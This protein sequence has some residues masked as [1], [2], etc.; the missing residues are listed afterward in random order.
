MTFFADSEKS[1]SWTMRSRNCL[2]VGPGTCTECS[3][4]RHALK[5]TQRPG[6]TE[7]KMN[8]P[9]SKVK[10]KNLIA[11]EVIELRKKEKILSSKLEEI[12]L[13]VDAESVFVDED[14][15]GELLHLFENIPGDKLDPFVRLFWNEQQKAFSRSNRGMRWHP[16]L[17]K[18]G[19]FIRQISP[20]LY[21]TLRN[22][23]IVKLPGQSTLRDYTGVIKTGA[24]FQH[25]VLLDLKEKASKLPESQKFV[26]I[27]HDEVTIQQ[28]LVFDK[29][30]STLVGYVAPEQLDLSK[31]KMQVSDEFFLT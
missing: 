21:D 13:R 4:V 6:V 17:I 7:L 30:S 26:C 31:V 25:H 16:M 28:D 5:K 12:Q 11:K 9:I 29:Q 23:G 1:S 24:G 15:N 19:I 22:M 8:A 18:F 20:A 10:N 2:Q 27:L 14:T 3:G